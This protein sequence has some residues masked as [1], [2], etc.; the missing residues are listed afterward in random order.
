MTAGVLTP[1]IVWLGKAS[2][3]RPVPAILAWLAVT[4]LT[5]IA[6]RSAIAALGY[7]AVDILILV[8]G[9]KASDVMRLWK[10]LVLAALLASIGALLWKLRT[11]WLRIVTF[12]AVLGYAFTVLAL[13]RI[14]GLPAA[15]PTRSAAPPR[16]ASNPVPRRVVWVIFDELDDAQSLGMPSLERLRHRA[17]SARQAWSPAKDTEES[18]PAL[19]SGHAI[20]GS[21][22]TQG[23]LILDTAAGPQPFTAEDSVFAHLPGGPRSAAVLGYFH[24]YCKLLTAIG[25]CHSFYLGNIGRWFD[26]LLFFS[27]A[28]LSLVRW[29]PGATEALPR[30]IQHAFNPMYRISA[31]TLDMLPALLAERDKELVFIHLNLPHYPAEFAQLA[32]HL[33]PTPDDRAAYRQNLLLVD[34]LLDDIVARLASQA[35]PPDTLL[36]VSSDHW[37]RIDSPTRARPIP[38]IAWHVGERDP[39]TLQQPIATVHTEALARDFLSGRITTH[40][41]LAAWWQGQPVFPTWIPDNYKH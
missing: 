25:E 27:E 8:I 28:A 3:T 31:D 20:H 19:L 10:L 2:R 33:A 40:A 26:S 4:A 39:Q 35:T 29:V 37:H 41:Q 1:T 23:R 24:P 32:L 12:T 22:F 11:R 14:V 21:G 30:A 15:R 38:F 34:R 18:L 13:W 16:A 6:L 9:Q 36:L 17:V 7:S 5:L